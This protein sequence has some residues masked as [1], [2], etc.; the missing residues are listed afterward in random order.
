MK[1]KAP[2]VLVEQVIMT[3]IRDGKTHQ[4]DNAISTGAKDGMLSM[5]QFVVNLYRAG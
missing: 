4:I 1:S 2:L 3:L 5:D